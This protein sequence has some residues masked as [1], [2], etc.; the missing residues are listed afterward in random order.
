MWIRLYSIESILYT[1]M[2]ELSSNPACLQRFTVWRWSP[3]LRSQP[4]CGYPRVTP[5]RPCWRRAP[6][7][8]AAASPPPASRTSTSWTWPASR[9]AG[10]WS[11]RSRVS[12]GCV[13]WWD[14]LPSEDSACPR[15]R[16]STSSASP[17][18]E[19]WPARMPSTSRRRCK[20]CQQ[21]L[22]T[23]Q[24]PW[25]LHLAG[26]LISIILPGATRGS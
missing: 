22:V 10:W 18:T 23:G 6:T 3:T 12:P 9:P 15:T 1:A 26:L 16:S 13:C 5:P 21:P 7:P 8:P 14:T 11:A 17:R 24:Q 4:Y 2:P 20:C 25:T 19:P